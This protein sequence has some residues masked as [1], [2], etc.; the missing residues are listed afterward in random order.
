MKGI[1]D[2]A[3]LLGAVTASAGR[4][5]AGALIASTDTPAPAATA[6]IRGGNPFPVS[7]LP[8][9]KRPTTWMT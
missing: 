4:S 7:E 3:V 2:M 1:T 5:T 8:K 9:G 6:V